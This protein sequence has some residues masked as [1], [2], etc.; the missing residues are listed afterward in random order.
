M[1][2]R[3]TRFRRRRRVVRRRRPRFRRRTF[4]RGRR[5]GRRSSGKISFQLPPLR[6]NN[7]TSEE[8]IGIQGISNW[9]MLG[10]QL[11]DAGTCYNLAER[12]SQLPMP[13]F[14]GGPSSSTISISG[15]DIQDHKM[16]G[17][18]IHEVTNSASGFVG[19]T[20]YFCVARR[21]LPDDVWDNGQHIWAGTPSGTGKVF[22]DF[23]ERSVSQRQQLE[24]G[25]AALPGGTSTYVNYWRHPSFSP[26]MASE[27]CKSFK[28]YKTQH[29]NLGP[30]KI[31][32]VSQTCG[33]RKIM[34]SQL[35][36]STNNVG[37]GAVGGVTRF[38]L[39]KAL[40][41]PCQPG[42]LSGAPV[43]NP[44]P[45]GRVTF[46]TP[47]LYTVTREFLRSFP[48]YPS[49]RRLAF[50]I[51]G[52][53]QDTTPIAEEIPTTVNVQPSVAAGGDAGEVPGA[54]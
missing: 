12:N 48:L 29:V 24:P 37:L 16:K 43:Q 50:A 15:Q 53:H 52:I 45:A 3:R 5:R 31:C 21:D 28:I 47:L 25:H 33:W 40:G 46:A 54:N 22:V 19:L 41:Q 10:K 38:L 11:L 42:D 35:K 26:F 51:S 27:F 18:L 30:G 1:A 32:R 39:V 4:R 2:R 36:A 14:S 23:F 13:M 7:I 8:Y 44:N 17:K 49:V 9:F 20:F 6:Y 34:K